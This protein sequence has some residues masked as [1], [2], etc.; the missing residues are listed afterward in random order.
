MIII[1]SSKLS[2]F[3]LH[4]TLLTGL[5]FVTHATAQSTYLIDLNNKTAIELG[6]FPTSL[7]RPTAIN[8]SGQVVGYFATVWGSSHAFITGPHGVGITDLGTLGGAQ[9]F[10]YGIND[11]GQVVGRS[12]LPSRGSAHA[13][14]TGVNGEG[15]RDL[16]PLGS[17]YSEGLAINGAGRVVGRANASDTNFG[18]AFITGPNGEGARD[19]GTL[20][21]NYSVGL[22]VNSSGQVVGRA[23][24]SENN[25]PRAFITGPNG[26]G[27]KE[28]SALT[29]H[30]SEAR[31]INDSGEVVGWSY[32]SPNILSAHAFITGPNG[33]GARDL[34]TLGGSFSEA[35]GINDSGEVVG[36]ADTRDYN[37]KHAFITGPKGDGMAD[38]NSLVDLPEGVIL[39]RAV[40]INNTGQVVAMAS[41]IPEP[42]VYALLLAGL[43]LI[44]FMNWRNKFFP[45]HPF[46][47]EAPKFLYLP[48]PSAFISK[49]GRPGLPSAVFSPVDFSHGF[50][51]VINLACKR[52]CSSVRS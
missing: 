15:M 3:I 1:E 5:S 43:C 14:I 47:Q 41:V 19:L 45:P 6:A 48:S 40:D 26:E 7:S 28:L 2:S 13:F 8:D 46:P 27:M 4:A 32:A 18:H 17:N 12:E 16:G 22:A 42:E 29:G 10:A 31:D 30:Y 51:C 35:L 52:R 33:E 20:G 50:H 38:L 24:T 21:G 37:T 34:G 23:Y 11:A 36:Q 39:T 44:R 49:L 25:F 9:S